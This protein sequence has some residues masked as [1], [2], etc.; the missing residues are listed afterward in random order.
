MLTA[1]ERDLLGLDFNV[2]VVWRDSDGNGEEIKPG[3]YRKDSGVKV[4]GDTSLIRLHPLNLELVA[5]SGLVRVTRD[6]ATSVDCKMEGEPV[7]YTHYKLGRDFQVSIE[8]RENKLT[9]Y[10]CA[11]DFYRERENP[12][13]SEEGDLDK[14][15]PI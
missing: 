12:L 8:V 6:K 3:F 7:E 11:I 1:E 5:N 2:E 4:I 14:E 15:F 9:E 10:A 13:T